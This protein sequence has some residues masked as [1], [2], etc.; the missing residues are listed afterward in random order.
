MVDHPSKNSLHS[1]LRFVFMIRICSQLELISQSKDASP[2]E[3]KWT[4]PDITEGYVGSKTGK[5]GNTY[6]LYSRK[7]QAQAWTRP[8][9]Q[10]SQHKRHCCERLLVPTFWDRLFADGETSN[11]INHRISHKSLLQVSPSRPNCFITAWTMI[12]ALL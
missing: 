12:S 2:D 11:S 6:C 7:V 8:T 4:P 3:N 5:C 9:L 1:S 10:F